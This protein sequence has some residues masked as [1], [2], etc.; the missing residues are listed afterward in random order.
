MVARLQLY[1][2]T[3]ALLFNEQV[4]Q[5][6]APTSSFGGSR[7]KN[8]LRLIKRR[9]LSIRYLSGVNV[10][11]S[12]SNDGENL[13]QKFESKIYFDISIDG[14]EI[15]RMIFNIASVHENILPLH[16]EN[17]IKLCGEDLKSIDPK[18]SYV[19]CSFKHSPQFVETMPQYRWAHVLDGRGRNAVGRA[20]D[21]ISDPD[22][23]R[24]CTHSCY[25][26]VYHGL[27]YDETMGQEGVVIT[28]PL[29][30]AYRGSTSFSIVRVGESPQEW[31]EK[32]LLNSAVL[33]WLESGIEVLHAMAR[34]TRAPPIVSG[35]GRL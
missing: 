21:R 15:G 22:G 26:G 4:V 10:D 12:Y 11:D 28:V 1:L 9:N 24:S 13:E 25:G 17:L 3:I 19:K 32:L 16:T 30:G 33:G 29:V 2:L 18:C 5:S 6:W 8:E 14:E 31:R 20:V 34:Q 23:I 27:N 35:S 7:T